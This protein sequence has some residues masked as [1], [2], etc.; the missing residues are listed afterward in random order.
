[1][2]V[3]VVNFTADQFLQTTDPYD[4]LVSLTDPVERD[5][6]TAAYKKFAAKNCDITAATFRTLLN[7]AKLRASGFGSGVPY[8]D[9]TDQPERLR[10]TGYICDDSGIMANGGGQYGPVRICQHP[11]LPIRQIVNYDTGEHK[12]EVAWRMN[13]KWHSLIVPRSTLAM[14]TRIVKPLSEC[15]IAVDSENAKQVVTYFTRL[16]TENASTLRVTHS[17]TRLGW[18]GTDKFLPYEDSLMF[19]GASEFRQMYNSIHEFGSREA[20][21][22]LAG[23]VRRGRSVAARVALAASFASALIKPLRKLPFFLHLWSDTSGTGKTVGLMLAA[24]VWADPNE[25]AYVKNMNTTN[26]GVEAMSGFL[27]S[28]PLCLDELCMKDGRS[29]YKGN[30]EDMVYQFCEGTGRSRGSRDGGMQ[31]QK[32]WNCCAISTG[33]TPLIKGTSRAGAV[34]RVLEIEHDTP[35]FD[36]PVTAANTIRDNYGFAGRLFISELLKP[37][38]LEEA[39]EW[40]AEYQREILDRSNTTDKQAMVA[41]IVLAADKFAARHVFD[42]VYNLR[43][44]DLVPMAKTLDEVDTNRRVYDWLMGVIA[45]NNA[46]FEPTDEHYNGPIWGKLDETSEKH[47]ITCIISS[48]FD[49]LLTNNGYDPSAF[50]KWARRRGLLKCSGG[51]ATML[52]RLSGVKTPVR[53]VC[54]RM[55][56]IEEEEKD[57]APDGYQQVEIGKED[58]PF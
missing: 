5:R 44:E 12:T 21:F 42:D 16:L 19:D 38:A 20:W 32:T 35:L 46:R 13:G 50:R 25:G 56:A 30:L 17:A 52:V 57:S 6:E 7:E 55:D 34:N 33:E 36:D 2:D 4:Y 43:A 29:G 41:S 14:A 53:C 26:V 40:Q 51:K 23:R 39:R 31:Q 9:F 18:I 58:M 48:R 54:I 8:T 37:G 10:C 24:S 22:D 15:G 45:E 1:M 47:A 28:L 3:Q 27:G 11:L 49:E